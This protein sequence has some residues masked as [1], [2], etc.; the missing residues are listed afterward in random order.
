MDNETNNCLKNKEQERNDRT[1][2]ISMGS[3][4]LTEIT[5]TY[6][7]YNVRFSSGSAI[8]PDDTESEITGIP[9]RYLQL[10]PSIID[11]IDNANER[12]GLEN[13]INLA[14]SPERAGAIHLH[15]IY[16]TGGYK[17]AEIGLCDLKDL[18]KNVGKTISQEEWS[19]FL[20]LCKKEGYFYFDKKI[21][22][23]VSIQDSAFL[24]KAKADELFILEDSRKILREK[25][26]IESSFQSFFPPLWNDIVYSDS[27]ISKEYPEPKVVFTRAHGFF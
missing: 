11:K 10:V 20:E 19:R 1:F 8:L 23:L 6:G 25:G 2:N 4:P 21:K 5:G 18:K 17:Q 3:D 16:K 22:E 13:I 27:E 14:A 26:F 9:L 7:K 15:L 12:C 24:E